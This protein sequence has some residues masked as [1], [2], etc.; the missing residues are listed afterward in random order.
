MLKSATKEAKTEYASKYIN[1]LPDLYFKKKRRTRLVFLVAILIGVLFASAGW[2][3]TQMQQQLSVIR[4]NTFA[5]KS[6]LSKLESERAQQQLLYALKDRIDQKA[7]L[8]GQI[9][10]NNRS[11]VRIIDAVEAGIPKGIQFATMDFSA[12]E[13]MQI[14]GITENEDEIPDLLHQL[15]SLNLF[16]SVFLQSITRRTYVT[17]EGDVIDY[18]FVIVCSFGGEENATDE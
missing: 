15:K 13:S 8:L 12:A 4:D 18:E 16:D 7:A 1:L 2:Y 3:Y 10:E 17:Y 14:L 9:E 11:A 6:Q 5:M